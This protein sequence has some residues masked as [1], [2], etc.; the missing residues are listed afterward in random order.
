MSAKHLPHSAGE[1]HAAMWVAVLLVKTAPQ[2]GAADK[3]FQRL[4]GL[5]HTS[6]EAMDVAE[7]AMLQRPDTLMAYA[8]REVH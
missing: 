3:H 2:T 5:F 7:A 4:P 6:C 1:K 8:C